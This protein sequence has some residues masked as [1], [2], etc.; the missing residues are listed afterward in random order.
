MLDRRLALLG[1]LAGLSACAAPPR[2]VPALSTVDIPP[3]L[4]PVR[5]HMR[6]VFDI[7]V[8]SRPFRAA[9]PRLDT[10]MLG[11]TLVVHNYGHGGSGWSLSWGCAQV[12]LEKAL[13]RGDRNLAVIGCGAL[14][15]TTAVLALKM[16]CSVTLYAKDLLPMTRSARATGIWT[17]DSR[18]ALQDAAAPG[19]GDL[20]ERMARLSWKT[21]R[22]YLGLPGTPVEFGD[23]Y[24][25]NDGRQQSYSPP[26]N[27]LAFA[28]YGNR[29]SDIVPTGLDMPPGSTPF[30]FPNVRRSEGLQFNIASYGHTLMGEFY[31]MGGKLEVR[32]FH[33][34][35]EFTQLKQKVVI[36]CTGYGARDLWKDESVV[37][38]RGQIAWLAP[39]PEVTYGVTY[40]DVSMIPRSDGIVVQM[41]EGGDMRGYNDPTETVD[42]AEAAEGV[43]RIAELYTRFK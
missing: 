28:H 3:R 5:A 7:T 1:G 40:R 35:S 9:G 10:E 37:P 22:S 25:V 34:P 17:P 14:G 13:A 8:C 15:L 41:L 4:M 33:A 6:R 32:E 36:N 12:V 42:R 39:Q 11:D 31:A 26:A 2:A 23:R 29:L 18:I 16:G 27:A 21:Y 19:F 43:A 30:Q 20:W 24:F 38:V